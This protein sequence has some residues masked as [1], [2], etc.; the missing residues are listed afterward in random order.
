MLHPRKLRWNPKPKKMMGIGIVEVF[1]FNVAF[2]R[3]K[4]VGPWGC[5]RLHSPGSWPGQTVWMSS[6]DQKGKDDLL[7]HSGTFML[8]HI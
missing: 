5:N 8:R 6:F 7:K 2:F 1:I 4:R 3:F